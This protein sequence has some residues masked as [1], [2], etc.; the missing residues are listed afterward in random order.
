DALPIF[1]PR[2]VGLEEEVDRE[3]DVGFVG[4]GE[5]AFGT[6]GA[7][8][9]GESGR[10]RG[11][12]AGDAEREDR[13]DPALVDVVRD[14]RT[15]RL[16]GGRADLDVARDVEGVVGRDEDSVVYR[17]PCRVT[18]HDRTEVDLD[19]AVVDDRRCV[20]GRKICEGA[21]QERG[22]GGCAESPG[23][24]RDSPL[25][26]GGSQSVARGTKRVNGR[27]GA[28]QRSSSPIPAL[29]YRSPLV[30]P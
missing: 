23:R 4:E 3:V 12:G 15:R 6:A 9:S 22:Q 20:G 30:E 19:V 27:V 28:L 25:A 2:D 17:R 21:C 24:H 13:D 8:R 1:V 14:R 18:E 5:R 29:P 16:G 26:W 7:D 11:G 10:G